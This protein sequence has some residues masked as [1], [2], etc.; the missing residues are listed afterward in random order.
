MP[1]EVIFLFWFL[2]LMSIPFPIFHNHKGGILRF[3]GEERSLFGN[4]SWV[5]FLRFP[6]SLKFGNV[7]HFS[8][9]C[10]G[11]I[12]RLYVCTR[13][14]FFNPLISLFVFYLDV[15]L[16]IPHFFSFVSE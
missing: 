15:A 12:C 7:L 10:L 1:Y 2:H 4:S 16:P 9:V 13:K 8:L 11:V 5:S 3:P 6:S 14:L